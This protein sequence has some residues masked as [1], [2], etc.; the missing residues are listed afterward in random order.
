MAKKF[1]YVCAGIL[2]LA[3]S[4]HFGATNAIGQGFGLI[5]AGEV[6]HSTSSCAVGHSIYLGGTQL[7]VPVPGSGKVIATKALGGSQEICRVMLENGD[8]YTYITYD[9]HIGDVRTWRYD[10]NA[11]GSSATVERKSTWGSVKVGQR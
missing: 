2:L 6:D 4:Y 9:L 1:F 7:P 3:L 10:G 8:L 5:E 11:L